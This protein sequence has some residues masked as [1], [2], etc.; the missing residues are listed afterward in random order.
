[1]I[2]EPAKQCFHVPAIYSVGLSYFRSA[3]I[4]KRIACNFFKRNVS[5]A[6][7]F[8]QLLSS[9][10]FGFALSVESDC[11]TLGPCFFTSD[12]AGLVS[13]SNPPH[14]LNIALAA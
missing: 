8:G 11:G 13:I 2:A 1:M 14:L 6:K 9:E 7:I 4:L 10:D 5:S 12:V 3:R